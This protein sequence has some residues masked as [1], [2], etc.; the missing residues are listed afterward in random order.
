MPDTSIGYEDV[1]AARSRIA[2]HTVVTELRALDSLGLTVKLE[3]TQGT[4]SFKLRGATNVVRA[5]MPAGV[6]AGSSGNH[7]TALA[8]AARDAGI[9]RA[10]IVMA[11]DHSEHKRSRIE[12]LGADVVVA[13]AGNAGRDLLAQRIAEEEGLEYV[14]SYD[15]PLVIAGQGTIGLEIL[16]ARNDVEAILV[17]VGG[18]GMIAGIAT[19]VHHV[20]PRVR[21]I[22]VEPVTANDTR[23]SLDAGHR[24][25]IEPPDTICDGVRAQTPGR[26]TFPI[27]QRLV[28]DVITVPDDAVAEAMFLL[29]REGLMIEPSGALSV[30]GARHLGLGPEAVC[31]LSGGNITPEAHA[32]LI[33]PFAS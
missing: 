25:T 31:V 14:S 27:I 2:G 5:L 4:G 26:R 22:G 21:V 29:W 12:R 20:A 10:V 16:E 9:G 7:G 30:A 17:P 15:H 11:A 32:S 18:G 1:L 19:A 13:D 23:R 8:F 24:V 33:A 3:N 6:V 28:D